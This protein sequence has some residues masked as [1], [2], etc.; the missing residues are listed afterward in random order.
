MTDPTSPARTSDAQLRAPD[1]LATLLARTVGGAPDQP[2]LGFHQGIVITWDQVA[3]TNTIMIGGSLVSDVPVLAAGSVL[4]GAND[5]VGILRVRTQYFILG[6]ISVL[7]QALTIRTALLSATSFAPSAAYTDLS[8]GGVGPTLS[9]VYIGPSRR[10]IVF[11]S[12]FAAATD[13]GYAAMHFQVTGASVINPPTGTSAF[14]KGAFTGSISADVGDDPTMVG[15]SA[16]RQFLVTAADG[17]NEGLNTFTMK[18][19]CCNEAGGSPTN[20]D[21]QFSE[22]VIIVMPL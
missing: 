17:L 20:N 11:L 4:I 9:N 14:S 22:R 1:V 2:E 6:R 12:A 10:C 13:M 16:S 18:Y 8:G 7:S 15:G 21:C 5:V 3:G 19:L